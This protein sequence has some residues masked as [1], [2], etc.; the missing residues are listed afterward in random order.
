MAN[1][2]STKKGA[3]LQGWLIAVALLGGWLLWPTFW[4]WWHNSS[5]EVL[6][7]EDFI[8]HG[9][10]R[11][12]IVLKDCYIDTAHSVQNSTGIGSPYE[13][14]YPLRGGPD[15][16][17]PFKI[18]VKPTHW[19]TSS[20]GQLILIPPN[21]DPSV[22]AGNITTPVMQEVS[23]VLA[24]GF[25]FNYSL[26]NLLRSERA[27]G[28]SDAML[29]LQ[30]D[31]PPAAAKG[32]AAA[33]IPLGSGG[34]GTF[35]FLRRN[36]RQE[37]KSRTRPSRRMATIVVRVLLLLISMPLLLM[38]IGG[39]AS[40]Y[41]SVTLP[42]AVMPIYSGGE[43]AIQIDRTITVSGETVLYKNN[44]MQ[45]A[46]GL[47]SAGLLLITLNAA[48]RRFDGTCCG[49]IDWLLLHRPRLA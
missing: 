22:N 19:T 27:G 25:D 24:V 32:L 40:S 17:R 16:T 26:R 10:D 47:F 36:R 9:S 39:I 4:I 38:A 1:F 18:F 34:L 23:G 35:L 48:L 20:D 8:A 33:T 45:L 49:P 44:G 2:V 37:V 21:G 11:E 42:P 41:V 29:L 13:C 6:T 7:L 31:R 43:G 30:N 3:S 14:Y 5:P 46:V 12:W 15:D 28:A